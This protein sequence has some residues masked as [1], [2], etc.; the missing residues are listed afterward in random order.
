MRAIRI[1]EDPY[2]P[3]PLNVRRTWVGLTL[4][5]QDTITTDPGGDLETLRSFP[6]PHDGYYYVATAVALTILGGKD[7]ESAQWFKNDPRFI[8]APYLAFGTGCCEEIAEAV[9][10]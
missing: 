7:P 4:P 6:Q 1:V 2:G 10:N 9:A 8:G 5:I 3:D